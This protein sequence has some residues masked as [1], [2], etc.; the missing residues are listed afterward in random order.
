MLDGINGVRGDE[1][2][3]KILA[4]PEIMRCHEQRNLNILL[5]VV[6]KMQALENTGSSRCC[7]RYIFLANVNE[8]DFVKSRIAISPQTCRK[9]I[10]LW[11]S[12]EGKALEAEDALCARYVTHRMLSR[13]NGFRADA[14]RG[15]IINENIMAMTFWRKRK[16]D[17]ALDTS[18]ACVKKLRI[19]CEY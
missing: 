19:A 6:Q 4:F 15:Q 11:A 8:S 9:N 2:P 17:F 10:L 12:W 13:T 14:S 3:M 5:D 1:N 18:G 16:N 7:K